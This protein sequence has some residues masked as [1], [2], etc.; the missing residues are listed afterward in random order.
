M[1]IPKLKTFQKGKRDGQTLEVTSLLQS[2]TQGRLAFHHSQPSTSRHLAI[3]HPFHP[4]PNLFYLC[5]LCVAVRSMD[6][7]SLPLLIY[8]ALLFKCK[9]QRA[10]NS[11]ALVSCSPYPKFH[12]WSLGMGEADISK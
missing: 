1:G 6:Q 8:K 3:P 9:F 5:V 12:G 7:V 2:G 11:K 4:I 10:Y